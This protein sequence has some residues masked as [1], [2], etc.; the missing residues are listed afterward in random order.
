MRTHTANGV[1]IACRRETAGSCRIC[2]LTDPDSP[3][4]RADY[5]RLY[6]GGATAF[7]PTVVVAAAGT[8]TEAWTAG[9]QSCC[10][11]QPPGLLTKAANFGKAIVSHVAAGRPEAD[12]AT[13]AARWAT[14]RAC[15]MFDAAG[16]TCRACGCVLEIKI[17]WA[18]QR[19]PIGKW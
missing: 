16:V 4:Y 7:A 15:P 9:G 17:R 8:P 12:A 14:C 18:E 1:E 5:A 6:G 19:C 3:H 2:D 11:G 13:V 10:G